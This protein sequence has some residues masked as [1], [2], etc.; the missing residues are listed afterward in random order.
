MAQF[1]KFALVGVSNTLLTF[2]VYTLLV[3]VFGVW[4][5]AASGIGF[6][7]GA[8]NGYL[9]NRRWTFRG[10]AG[11]TATAV[12]W[13]VV[14]GCGLLVNLGLVYLFV[15]QAGLDK[16]IGQ[17]FATVIVVFITFFVNRRWTFRMPALDD[18][19]AAA[20]APPAAVR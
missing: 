9:L 5:L 13:V 19:G 20:V 6:A 11:G 2:A 10:H 4:Y 1:I 14:Q 7:V 17:A 18:V 8:V 3:K 16:L 12:R 15:S